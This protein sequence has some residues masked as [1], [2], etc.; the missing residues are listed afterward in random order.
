MEKRN[1]RPGFFFEEPLAKH[2]TM[3]VGG[4]AEVLFRPAGVEALAD[5]FASLPRE[6]EVRLL[7]A[8]SNLIVA[9]EGVTGVVVDTAL[10]DDFFPEEGLVFAQAG[11]KCPRL[12]RF[13]LDNGLAQGE[14]FLGIPGTVGGALAMNAGAFGAS[15]WDKVERVLVL[16]RDGQVRV[17][18]KTEFHPG[19][20]QI[21]RLAGDGGLEAEWFLGAWFAFPEGEREEIRKKMLQISR[22]RALTQPLSLPSAGSVFVNPPGMKSARL[23]EEAG[24][25][26]ERLGDAMVSPLHANFM[27]NAGKARAKDMLDLMRLVSERVY[28]LFGVRLVSEVRLWG[29]DD[30]LA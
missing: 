8:G 16:A 10:L 22:H 2:T 27:V 30:R 6:R 9:D 17:R 4:P 1:K 21:S 7:G 5:F 12:A 11:V 14:F 3:K 13:L 19:Y 20:R 28:H 26:G 29:S 18:E 25:K 23:I 24:L 15:T